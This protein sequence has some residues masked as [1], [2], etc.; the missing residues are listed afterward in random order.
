MKR[1]SFKNMGKKIQVLFVLLPL[2]MILGGCAG[3][4]P[5]NVDVELQTTPPRVKTT[6]YTEALSDLG[7]MTEIYG[8]D[9]LFIQSNPIGDKTGTSSSTGGE[10]PRDITEMMKSSLNSI[11]GK[12]VFIP[13]D[14][15]FIQNSMVTGYSNFDNKLVPNVVLSGGITEFDRGLVTR[16]DNTDA[17]A[18]ADF[19]GMPDWLPSQ[20]VSLKYRDTGKQGR[21]NSV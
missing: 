13:Y 8:T 7:L 6:S 20:E 3:L 14:P 16:G 17:S 21:C 18:S 11:G 15:N 5:H 10:I 9:M 1:N 2:T 4:N 19:T 12:V